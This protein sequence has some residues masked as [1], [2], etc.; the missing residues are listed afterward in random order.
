MAKKYAIKFYKSKAWQE[1]RAGYINSVNGLCERCLKRGKYKPG[2]IVHHI[3]YITRNN[4][5]DPNVTLNWE[6]LE[7]CCLECHNLEHHGSG[8]AVRDDVMFDEDG[9]LIQK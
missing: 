4:I 7:F 3:N 8:I 2:K 6:N 5:N 1:C 9:N